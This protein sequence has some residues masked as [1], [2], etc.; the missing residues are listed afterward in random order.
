MLL[1]DCCI[2]HT[3]QTPSPSVSPTL[4]DMAEG[5]R[6]SGSTQVPTPFLSARSDRIE[7]AERLNE[8]VAA[9]IQ[10]EAAAQHPEVPQASA[11]HDSAKEHQ[12]GR[13]VSLANWYARAAQH[14][15]SA[16]CKHPESLP[17]GWAPKLHISQLAP[18][19]MLLA[20]TA[21]LTSVH[22]VNLEMCSHLY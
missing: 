8:A 16:S 5:E 9:D 19:F 14:S 2:L 20:C 7:E 15:C 1:F 21:A 11:V 6:V 10:A 3:F 18:A 4:D 22:I 12:G 17:G 13:H